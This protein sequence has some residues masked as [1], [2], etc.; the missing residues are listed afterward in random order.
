MPI[1]HP[2]GVYYM[3]CPR[4]G[5]SQFHDTENGVIAFISFDMSDFI[6][7]MDR[8]EY[9]QEITDEIKEMEGWQ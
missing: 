9:I 1:Y 7:T 4:C 2:Q 3:G 6:D 8:I 5:C